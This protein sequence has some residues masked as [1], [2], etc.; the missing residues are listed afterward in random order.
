MRKPA[1]HIALRSLGK[2]FPR[3]LEKA[4]MKIISAIYFALIFA[5]MR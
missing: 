2:L 4:G 3:M 5:G 1:A